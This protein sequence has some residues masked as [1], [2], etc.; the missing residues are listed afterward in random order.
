MYPVFTDPL[1]LFDNISFWVPHFVLRASSQKP[2][3]NMGRTR[4]STTLGRHGLPMSY[5]GMLKK[6]SNL[7]VDMGSCFQLKWPWGHRQSLDKPNGATASQDGFAEF[8][9]Q[10]EAIHVLLHGWGCPKIGDSRDASLNPSAGHQEG[11]KSVLFRPCLW[12]HSGIIRNSVL[13]G[14]P[15]VACGFTVETCDV[16]CIPGWQNLSWII[17]DHSPIRPSLTF[18]PFL[19]HLRL[20]GCRNL[21]KS[22][23]TV[24]LCSS[25]YLFHSWQAGNST[26]MG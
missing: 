2:T 13:C 16:F 5:L 17:C 1:L 7:R 4:S 22:F 23:S 25:V 3:Q 15:A 18:P 8:L 26:M 14:F 6:P 19:P 20:A 21:G 10:C 9:I 24:F 12:P 11:A